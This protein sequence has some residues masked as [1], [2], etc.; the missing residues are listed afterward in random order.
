M[1]RNGDI[2]SLSGMEGIWGAG[3]KWEARDASACLEPLGMFFYYCIFLTILTSLLKVLCLQM[4]TS[5]VTGREGRWEWGGGSRYVA[6]RA[7][8]CIF[9]LKRLSMITTTKYHDDGQPLPT[10][11][12]PGKLSKGPVPMKRPKRCFV[13]VWAIS[14]FFFLLTYVYF[15]IFLRFFYYHYTRK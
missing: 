1:T 4:M 10:P 13:V 11:S 9:F 7:P 8:A 15:L 3:V 14:F 6:S 2:R 5:R 12:T